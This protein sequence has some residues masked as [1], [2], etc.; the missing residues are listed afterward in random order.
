MVQELVYKGIQEWE[1]PE[2]SSSFEALTLYPF[3]SYGNWLNRKEESEMSKSWKNASKTTVTQVLSLCQEFWKQSYRPRKWSFSRSMRI[4]CA[5]MER[6]GYPLTQNNRTSHPANEVAFW[7][8]LFYSFL[9]HG[10][11]PCSLQEQLLFAKCPACCPVNSHS[12]KVDWIKFYRALYFQTT[13]TNII[14]LNTKP[15]GKE[16]RNRH[17]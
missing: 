7:S 14:L 9:L 11:Q 2:D 13:S 3:L 1:E 10:C 17:F 16:K 12:I 8:H 6:V 15:C 5:E 4:N